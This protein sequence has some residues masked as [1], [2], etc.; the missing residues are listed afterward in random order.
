MQTGV[1][2][3]AKATC[4]GVSGWLTCGSSDYGS[5]YFAVETNNNCDG[6]DN[7]CD[8]QIDE[9]C[10]CLDGVNQTCGSDIGICQ[11]GIQ[12]CSSGL[13]G[14]CTNEITPSTEVCDGLDNDC[15][16]SVD[17]ELIL[18]CYSG[19]IGTDGIG[20]C[21][22]GNNVCTTGVWS[23]CVGEVIPT[24][25]IC[26]NLDNN[27]NGLVDET[28]YDTYYSYGEYV[29]NVSDQVIINVT[30]YQLTRIVNETLVLFSIVFTDETNE[31]FG[32][33]T[34]DLMLGV[35]RRVVDA[36]L[37][38]QGVTLNA[39]RN[40]LGIANVL[41][42]E[43]VTDLSLNFSGTIEQKDSVVDTTQDSIVLKAPLIYER[44]GE[45]GLYRYFT[46]IPD[47]VIK[48]DLIRFGSVFE[49]NVEKNV[50]STN[51][52]GEYVVG[53]IADL[54]SSDVHL[55]MQVRPPTVSTIKEAFESDIK[56]YRKE[57]K[58]ES[59]YRHFENVKS[60][61]FVDT[62][63]YQNFKLERYN[64]VTSQWED[65]STL[66][67]FAVVD[68]K[69]QFSGF[70]L[71]E[72]LFR[73]IGDPKPVSG[74]TDQSAGAGAGGGGGGG[75][76]SSG[77]GGGGGSSGGGGYWTFCEENWTCE[78]W[79]ECNDEGKMYRSCTDL[80]NCSTYASMPD[81][82]DY[83]SIEIEEKIVE[84]VLKEETLRERLLSF[85]NY[86]KYVLAFGVVISGILVINLYRLIRLLIIEKK[87]NESKRKGNRF[88]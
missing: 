81:T 43:P 57:I 28:C 50:E 40:Y 11:T 49:N 54:A 67:N 45:E 70:S 17:E 31:N 86:Y 53:W 20:V 3:G 10:G 55:E 37:L 66:Y 4:G 58:I 32:T 34:F 21:T 48:D 82:W 22:S 33:Y 87:D 39:G 14:S 18:N 30:D 38:L 69:A 16:S 2:S 9:G 75:G 51:V 44:Y 15:D 59:L 19:P 88:K 41:F 42:L 80:N 29:L 6:L 26:D 74:G 5:N 23:T 56:K 61:V 83:C 68:G 25:E 65:V 72:E 78:E 36:D 27:C 63:N 52:S 60:E 62:L 64:T 76:G 79:L 77:G 85:M 12:T 13:W 24:I 1:C 84:G 7:D 47:W 71:S 8:G 46:K 35:P 73:I